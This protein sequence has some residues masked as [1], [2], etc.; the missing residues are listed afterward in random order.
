MPPWKEQQ[1][2]VRE[3]FLF[4][5][6]EVGEVGVKDGSDSDSLWTGPR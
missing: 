3:T 2:S 5:D 1:R 4:L 6:E